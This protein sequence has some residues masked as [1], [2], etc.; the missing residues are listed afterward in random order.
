MSNQE[1]VKTYFTKGSLW[2][3]SSSF[4]GLREVTYYV[5]LDEDEMY[6]NTL[7]IRTEDDGITD[8][9]TSVSNYKLDAGVFI[10]ELCYVG[11]DCS[12]LNKSSRIDISFVAKWL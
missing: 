9:I 6:I 3:K 1:L 10:E 2:K 8:K 4:G 11:S 7:I 12:Y 5:V